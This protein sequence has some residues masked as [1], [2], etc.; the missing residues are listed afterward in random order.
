MITYFKPILKLL[1]SERKK[2]PRLILFFITLSVLDLASIGL[3]G[4]YISLVMDGSTSYDAINK[5]GDM[6][7]FLKDRESLLLALGYILLGVFGAKTIFAIW[8]NREII[9]FSED[10]QVRLKS[11]LMH[12]YQSLP[13]SE[14][15]RRNSSEYI[16]SIQQ[17]TAQ[18][19]S[20][21]VLPLLRTISDGIVTFFILIFLAWQDIFALTLLLLLLGIIVFLNDTFFRDNLKTY[22]EKVNQ[23]ST[24]TIQGVREGIEGLKEIRILGKELYFYQAVRQGAKDQAFFGTKALTLSMAPKYIL[25]LTM[26]SFV[27][28]FVLI[29]LLLENNINTLIPTLGVFGVAS[30]RLFPAVNTLVSS[31]MQLRYSRD[32][33]L[34]L[35]NDQCQMK[36][37]L[38]KGCNPTPSQVLEQF[39]VLKLDC[40]SFA[41]HQSKDKALNKISLEIKAGESIGL[42]GASGSGKTTLVDMLL[43][44][45]EPQ[46]GSI[47][48]NGKEFKVAMQQWQSQVAYLPQQVF[49]IDNTLRH[50]VALGVNND[51]IDDD[52]IQESLRQAKLTEV[53]ER[54]PLGVNTILGESGVRLSG[55]QRQRVALARAFYHGRD[56]LV[57]D[58]ATSALDNETEQEIVKEIDQL[59]GKKTMIVIAHRLTTL[60]HCDRIYKLEDGRVT[61]VGSYKE[62]I[63]DA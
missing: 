45:L 35:Y 38:S 41:Y 56:V 39:Q 25:E 60:K 53:V 49:L 10:Q 63:E 19:S 40:V 2:V 47:K 44:L 26:V 5:F 59:K 6:F 43:G 1:D 27:V 54:L 62:L 16:Y 4:P 8:I 61:A 12:A 3:M 34:R 23:A 36:E 11:F 29:S 48:Y 30:L 15:I 33:V 52:K 55:G 31:L 42:I 9:Q 17:L 50:N 37:L 24:A 13:Y 7:G 20:Q 28:F 58:E 32:A 18:Y 14:Y 51:E 57:M 22:G 21:V 46:Q